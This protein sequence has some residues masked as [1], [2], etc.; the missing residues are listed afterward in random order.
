MHVIACFQ[1]LHVYIH[2]SYI[3]VHQLHHKLMVEKQNLYSNCDA[4][5][6]QCQLMYEGKVSAERL[7]LCACSR[8]QCVFSSPNNLGCCCTYVVKFCGV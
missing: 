3:K 5:L 2:T 6:Q 8:L 1:H 7:V 4:K